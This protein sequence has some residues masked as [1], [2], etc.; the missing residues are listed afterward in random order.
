M[1]DFRAEAIPLAAL[2]GMRATPA[3]MR[4]VH[5]ATGKTLAE[6]L[7]DPDV[8][9]QMQAAVF[10]ELHRRAVVAGQFPDPAA[11]WEEAG[12]TEISMN[13]DMLGGGG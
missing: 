3:S 4:A 10:C 6:L 12:L 11:L 1:T 2:T 8:S 7:E 9:W 5:Q 13:P